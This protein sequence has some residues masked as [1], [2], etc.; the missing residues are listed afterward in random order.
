M[1]AIEIRLAAIV[2]PHEIVSRI[3]A[4]F[5]RFRTMTPR[6]V[7]IRL[8]TTA[9]TRITAKIAN[10]SSALT[11]S[12]PGWVSNSSTRLSRETSRPISRPP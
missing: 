6:M 3:R 4:T 5:D 12:K 8:Q 9:I 1:L 11:S 10:T 7:A 2:N